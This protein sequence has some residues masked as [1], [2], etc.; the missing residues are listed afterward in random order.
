MASIGQIWR[1]PTGDEWVVTGVS[2]PTV[3]V[4]GQW[5]DA[6]LAGIG[7]VRTDIPADPGGSVVDLAGDDQPV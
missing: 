6:D 1:D 3:H 2:G 5:R 7:W 4:G